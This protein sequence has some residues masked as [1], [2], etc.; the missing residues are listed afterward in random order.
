MGQ[1]YGKG[2]AHR[3][4]LRINSLLKIIYNKSLKPFSKLLKNLI[5]HLPLSNFYFRP[6]YIDDIYMALGLWEPYVNEFF[7]PKKGDIILDVGSHIGY[8]TLIAAHRAGSEGKIICVEPD[9]RN[10]KLL[11][12]NIV[13]NGLKNIILFHGALGSKSGLTEFIID[14]NPLESELSVESNHFKKIISVKMLTMDALMEKLHIKQVDWIKIDVEGAVNDVLLGGKTTLQNKNK[15]IIE[16]RGET[17]LRILS[18]YG[19]TYYPLLD[20]KYNYYLAKK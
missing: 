8:F 9:P 18:D 5:T 14:E 2:D 1:L 7:T 6:Y 13:K 19:Y 11:K 4:L 10:Y 16:T 20:P 12:M 15:M 3:R 17:T